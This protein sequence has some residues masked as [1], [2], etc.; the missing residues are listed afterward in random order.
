MDFFCTSKMPF[1]VINHFPVVSD[2]TVSAK[3]LAL[4]DN[5][6]NYSS[7]IERYLKP[8]YTGLSLSKKHLCIHKNTFFIALGSF[9]QSCL[10]YMLAGSMQKCLPFS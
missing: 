3:M 6:L 9:K 4:G 8:C 5:R 1:Q 2:N 10:P 7:I